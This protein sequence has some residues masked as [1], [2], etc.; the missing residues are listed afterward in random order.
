[1]NKKKNS[2]SSEKKVDERIKN[3]FKTPEK[4]SHFKCVFLIS[5][6]FIT[7]FLIGLILGSCKCSCDKKNI[8]IEEN[9]D[10]Y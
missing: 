9:I 7:G 6:F 10:L 8:K 1:M 2:F 3:I 4:K 5:T